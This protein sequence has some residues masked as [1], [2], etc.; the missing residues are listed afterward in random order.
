MK[1]IKKFIYKAMVYRSAKGFDGNFYLNHYR[2]LKLK[3]KRSALAHYVKYGRSEGK[4]LNLQEYLDGKGG[5][6]NE[7]RENFDITAYKFFNKDLVNIYENDEDFFNH[8]VNNGRFEGR[9]SQFTSE[10]SEKNK[11]DESDKWKSIFS[12]SDF[13][14]FCG[15][16]ISPT[17][18][19]KNDAIEIFISK[20]INELWPINFKYFFDVKFVKDNKLIKFED[21]N[22][23][24]DS[25][26]YRHWLYFGLPN[27]V[28]PNE[29]MLLSPYLGD[30]PYPM[31]FNWRKF[32]EL[33]G[34]PLET[35]RSQ[36]LIH[37]FNSSPKKINRHIA[38]MG[39]DAAWLLASIGRRA[40][41]Q[42]DYGKAVTL[43]EQSRSIAPAAEPL[44]LLGDAYREQGAIDEALQA[45]ADAMAMA[46]APIWPFLHASTIHASRR[47]FAEAFDVLR[48]AFGQ[49]RQKVEFGQKLQEITQLYFDHQ[50]ARAN[51]L[52]REIAENASDLVKRSAIDAMLNETLDN[53]Q[54]IYKDLGNL[55]DDCGGNENGYISILAND[56]LRQCTYYRVEQKNFQFQNSDVDVK[57]FS[58]ADVAGFINSLV[59]AKAAIF[60]RVAAFPHVL[61]AIL[62]ANSMGIKTYYEIDDLIFDPNI[63]PDP[64]ESF[65]GQITAAE[66]AGLQ[67]GVPLFRYAMA[68]CK[69]SIASTPSLSE[70]MQPITATR[71]SIVIRNGLDER[72]DK[73]ILMGAN[74]IRRDNGRIRIFYGSG[75]KAHNADFNR[76]VAPALLDLMHSYDHVDLVIVGHLKIIPDLHGMGNRI[77]RY[78][79]ISD[80]NHYWSILAGCDINL[81]VLEPGPVA[82]C[83]SEIKWLEAAILQIPSIVSGT[84][85]Y[86]ELLTQGVDGVVADSPAEWHAALK[87]LIDSPSQRHAIGERAR[88]KALQEYSVDKAAEIIANEFGCPDAPQKALKKRMKVLICNAFYAPQSYGGATRVVEDNVRTFKEKYPDMDVAVFCSEDGARP[89]GKLRV[90]AEN[91]VPVY[92]LSTPQEVNMDW[93]PFN[94]LNS[95]L[96]EQVLDHFNPDIIHFHCVQRLTASIVEVAIERKIPY[97]VTLHDAWWISDNQFLVDHDGLL[98]IPSADIIADCEN[99]P[100]GVASISRRQRLAALLQ[101]SYANLS[102]STSFEKIYA[103]A[104][105]RNLRTIENGTPYMR[106]SSR[107]LRSDGRIALGHIGGRSAHKGAT[108]IEAT[109]KKGNYQNLHLTMIDGTLGLGQSV[110]TMWGTTPVTLT[111]PFAQAEIGKLYDQLDVLLA[112]ST[113]PESFGL[114]TR[115]A[116]SSGLWV[117]ASDL[118]AI[119]QDVVEGHNGHVIDVQTPES[120]GQVLLKIDENVDRYTSEPP[121]ALADVRRMSDQADD[122]HMLYREIY[123]REGAL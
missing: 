24:I 91:S 53:I 84:K 29:N 73:A 6:N 98:K 32:S 88:H 95:E 105:I 42:S 83:K 46:R 75:T 36:A 79:F 65:E 94:N 39:Q 14:S 87:A 40:L 67:F 80:T 92:R 115:E 44:C 85:T 118:G 61:R 74:P 7:L 34:L 59:G 106:K 82:D 19:D 109:L 43:L 64:F 111:A 86:R 76:L 21:I 45:Y 50:S 25:D 10:N 99:S 13:L 104:A 58:H 100:H 117:V 101:H 121:I 68:M 47:N 81:A 26:Y 1:M 2:D 108:L 71:S 22:S 55:P 35:T 119:G 63:Y 102:V 120:L 90:E 122:L 20:G 96:F 30:M 89:A 18:V 52:Y 69:A 54:G 123:E 37:L 12:V 97:V 11:I 77:F 3:N 27:G 17:P 5:R 66:Y 78:D 33:S 16:K 113:W 114:V 57:I 93:R 23:N 107:A 56:D 70:K 28:A 49:W 110:D 41:M 4:F 38:L 103:N 116:L 62:Y 51:A 72:N 31:D 9:I 60:Y 112:P 48:A 15:D 8:Y